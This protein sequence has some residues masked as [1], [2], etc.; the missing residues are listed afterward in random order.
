MARTM[1]RRDRAVFLKAS[2]GAGCGV[3]GAGCRA[4]KNVIAGN[5]VANAGCGDGPLPA[6]LPVFLWG[7]VLSGWG[8]R[9]GDS[10]VVAPILYRL[11][12]RPEFVQIVAR[13]CSGDE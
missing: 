9:D 10:T 2:G 12:M 11:D 6:P 8:G 7:V 13:E 3:R 1:G 4:L 5:V